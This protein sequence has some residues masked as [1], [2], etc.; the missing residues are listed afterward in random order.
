[1]DKNAG[2]DA[3]KGF[4]NSCENDRL[5]YAEFKYYMLHYLSYAKQRHPEAYQGIIGNRE[6][7]KAYSQAESSFVKLISAYEKDLKKI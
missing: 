7:C 3:W 1:M 2:W 6:F 5:A 4:I